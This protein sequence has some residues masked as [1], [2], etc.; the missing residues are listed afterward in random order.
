MDKHLPNIS[1]IV[2]TA[3][4][5]SRAIEIKRCIESIRLSS[6]EPINIIVVANGDRCD[7][8]ICKWLRSQDDIHY[9]YIK[10]ASL[11]EAIIHG[12]TLVTTP[13]FSTIDDDDE[14]LKG[15]TDRKLSALIATPDADLVITN[16]YNCIDGIDKIL[17]RYLDEV[18]SN[19]LEQL[20][21]ENWLHNCNALYRTKTIG[22]GY[23][24]EYHAYCE[25]TWLAYK[26]C[27]NK[28]K[29]EVIDEPTFRYHD[30]PGS[31][32]KT[33]EYESAYLNSSF[34]VQIQRIIY[35]NMLN[36]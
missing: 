26:L 4:R 24:K 8:N 22:P 33:K 36:I 30:T 35:R 11:P 29:L 7:K 28:K 18:K 6:V 15:G 17:Y 1:V 14:Y 21:V 20:F 2:P 10:M 23:F 5:A 32:S 27:L 19:P 31:L 12:R 13:Y 16:G 34:G 3:A 9:E 25:W